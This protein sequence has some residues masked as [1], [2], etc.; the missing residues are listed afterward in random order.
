MKSRNP[1]VVEVTRGPLIESTHDVICVVADKRRQVIGYA[2][3]LDYVISPRSSIK[4]LQALPLLESGAYEAFGLNE[5][6]LVLSCASHKAEK[7]QLE[8]LTEWL[9]LIK[10]TESVLRC[11][12][13]ES[14]KTPLSHNC[15]GKHMGMVTAALQM[16]IDPT[17]YD[18]FEHPYQIFLRKYLSEVTAIDFSKAP[19]G[20]DGCCIPTYGM[21][22]QKLAIGMS[23]FVSE[24]IGD[25]R[26]KNALRIVDAIKKYPEYLSGQND[27]TQKVISTSGGKAIVKTGAEGAFTGIMPQQGLVFAL[28]VIDGHSR[29]AEV[30]SLEIFKQYGALSPAETEKLKEFSEPAVLNS[31]NEKV[32]F[33]RVKPMSK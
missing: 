19:H 1:L 18:K 26:R 11:G 13:S 21:S 10:K 23:V 14:S 24:D 31:R 2:G 25:S 15:S 9:G 32:G 20:I 16:K 27:F 6:H 12:P 17:D 5:K 3:H 7:H 33:I 30:A 8:A 22:I 4:P 28:K 29:A